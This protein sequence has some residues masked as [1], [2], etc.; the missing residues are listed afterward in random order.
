MFTK[1]PSVSSKAETVTTHPVPFCS[2]TQPSCKGTEP[3]HQ[4]WPLGCEMEVTGVA[5]SLTYELTV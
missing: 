3:Y 5:S 2:P 1:G 4:F